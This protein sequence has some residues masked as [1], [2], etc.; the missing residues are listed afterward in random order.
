MDLEPRLRCRDRPAVLPQAITSFDDLNFGDHQHVLASEDIW[1]KLGRPLDR[2]T[3]I[4]RLDKIR[5]IR[6]KVMHF[7]L[8]PVSEDAVVKLRWFNSVLHQYRD[9]AL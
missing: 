4:S 2:S 3:F 7:H 8:D 6:N 1:Q 5:D 9:P